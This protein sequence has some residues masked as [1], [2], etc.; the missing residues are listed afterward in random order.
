MIGNP[1]QPELAPAIRSTLDALRRRIRVY[2]WLHGLLLAAG[3]LGIAFWA[4]LAID[5][6]FEPPVAFRVVALV[7]AALGLAAVALRWIVRRAFVRLGPRNLAMLIERRF[8]EFDESLLTAVELAE[9]P[10]DLGPHYRDM[11]ARTCTQ[12]AR[13]IPNVSLRR[14]FNPIP[15][16]RSLLAALLLAA[17]FGSLAALQPAALGVWARRNLLLGDELWPRRTRLVIEGF[18]DG[19]AKVARGADFDVVVK[20]DLSMPIVPGAVE[21]RYRTDEGARLRATMSREGAADPARDEFQHYA[22]TFHGVLTPIRFDVV[23]GDAAIR[24]LRID[25][26]DSPILV[27]MALECRYPDYVDQAPR[28]LPVTGVMAILPGTRV[29]VRARANKDLV[30]VEIGDGESAPTRLEPGADRRSFSYSIGDFTGD[31]AL[32]ISL[33]DADGI[34]SREPARLALAAVADQAPKLAVHPRGIGPAI[35]SRAR[36]PVAGR[37]VDDYG[38]ERIWF[39]Y[40]LDDGEPAARPLPPPPANSTEVPFDEAL[41]VEAL[42]LEPGRRLALRV[43]AADRY[44]LGEEPNMGASEPWQFDVVTPEQLRTRLEARE[45]V[46]RQRFERIIEEVSQTRDA[47]G[48]IDFGSGASDDPRGEPGAGEAAA[49]DEASEPDRSAALKALRVQR[50]LQNAR[51]NAHE[52]LGVVESV[53][54][55]RAELINN[56]IDTE[57]LKIRLQEGIAD[58]LRRVADEMFAELE[59]RFDR[60][61]ADLAGDAAAESRR[62]ALEQVDAILE[63]MRRVLDRMIQLE[64]F[65]KVVEMLR[66][67]IHSQEQLSE[68][69]REQRKRGLRDLL[70]D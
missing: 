59:R 62:L 49:D 44:D 2:V 27:E 15:L 16:R 52:T 67:I 5:W 54:D 24:D 19:S 6:L 10:A 25:V 4:S 8:P 14:V 18:D 70:E 68:K 65:S 22:H 17:G 34:R 35:T 12:A 43:R 26:V 30:R 23:G 41:E 7:A 51:K 28:T 42:G 47:I 40:R 1:R 55:V 64:D 39:E 31:T 45:L 3:W 56:R 32:R 58:P 29:T 53:L 50:A 48:Q 46:I 38:I 63:V 33:L 13:S 37:I 61:E 57:E 21:I 9:C 11:L 69:T 20:A 36:V 60:L 66:E